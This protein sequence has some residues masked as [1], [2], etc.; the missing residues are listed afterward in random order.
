MKKFNPVNHLTVRS[1]SHSNSTKRIISRTKDDNEE[2]REVSSETFTNRNGSHP[3]DTNE[4]IPPALSGKKP[5][6]PKGGTK[7]L[8]G[9]ET[10]RKINGYKYD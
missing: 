7:N 1:L 8:K 9:S 2:L 4:D 6:K 10:I 3:V 5:V